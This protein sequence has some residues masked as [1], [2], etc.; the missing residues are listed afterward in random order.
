MMNQLPKIK[1]PHGKQRSPYWLSI[2]L[3]KNDDE[4]QLNILN[5]MDATHKVLL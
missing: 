5:G 1:Q 2:L 3:L 4:R